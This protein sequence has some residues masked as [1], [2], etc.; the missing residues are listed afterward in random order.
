[1]SGQI[2]APTVLAPEK[3]SPLPVKRLGVA[4]LTNG[5][6]P[7]RSV[8][9]TGRLYRPLLLHNDRQ[10]IQSETREPLR[11]THSLFYQEITTPFSYAL[12]HLHVCF[13]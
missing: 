2:H 4:C 10:E 6:H 3:E 13:V 5:T 9:S 1:M 8:Q 7:R 12:Q 11:A